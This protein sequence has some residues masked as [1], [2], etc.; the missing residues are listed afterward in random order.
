MSVTARFA[1]RFR[2]LALLQAS[3]VVGA[4][5]DLVFAVFMIVAP[6]LPTR[7]LR[8]PLP[9]EAFYL[10]LMAVLLGMLACLYLLAAHDPRR[11]SGIIVVAIAGRLCGALALAVAGIAEP[12][13]LPG[14]AVLAVCDF[15]L[16][17]APALFWLPLRR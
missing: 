16:G 2:F 15:A 4:V 8:L 10:W 9:G 3:L 17:L 14:I 13:L 5:Y 12:R 7:I 6:G 11:Y 1:H